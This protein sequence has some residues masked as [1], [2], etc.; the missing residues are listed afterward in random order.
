MSDW[1]RIVSREGPAVWRT[2][3]RL[4]GNHADAEE[5]FQETFLAALRLSGVEPLRDERAVLQRLTVAR[6]M[7]RLRQRYRRR[8]REQ[9]LAWESHPDAGASPGEQ[10]EAAELSSRLRDALSELPPRQAEAFCLFCLE[11]WTYEQIG[12]HLGCTIDN[13]GVLLHRARA[14]LRQRLSA[15]HK[16]A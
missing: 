16:E 8:G 12:G 9:T 15:A 14:A 3:Y 11:G 5:C 4:L 13:V 2:A 6:A 7:D 1:N 10:A